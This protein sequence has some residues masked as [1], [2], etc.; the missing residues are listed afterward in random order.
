MDTRRNIKCKQ[1]K[2]IKEITFVIKNLPTK[3][4]KRKNAS[5]LSDFTG[6]FYQKVTK[7]I[8]PILLKSFNNKGG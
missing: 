3:N 1:P 2:S 5:G 4:R 7:E 8:T 6:E